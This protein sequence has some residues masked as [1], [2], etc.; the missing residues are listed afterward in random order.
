MSWIF[1]LIADDDGNFNFKCI[2]NDL[3]IDTGGTSTW[4]K[5]MSYNPDMLKDDNLSLTP[6]VVGSN[7]VIYFAGLGTTAE[8]INTKGQTGFAYAT[9]K[10]IVKN[11]LT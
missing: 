1:A 9:N 2:G 11:L 5:T 3:L 10:R 8:A 6:K 7:H 4:N